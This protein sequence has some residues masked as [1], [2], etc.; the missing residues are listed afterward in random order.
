MQT[1]QEDYYYQKLLPLVICDST[2]EVYL[3]QGRKVLQ[4]GVTT[5]VLEVRKG[6]WVLCSVALKP[7]CMKRELANVWILGRT[8]RNS[9]AFTTFGEWIETPSCFFL[10]KNCILFSLRSGCLLKW[11]QALERELLY[12]SS[13]HSSEM[14]CLILSYCDDCIFSVLPFF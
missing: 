1:L 6:G 7:C 2:R 14:A 13:L 4:N 9:L 5:D 10:Y 3:C 12:S 11:L 8:L